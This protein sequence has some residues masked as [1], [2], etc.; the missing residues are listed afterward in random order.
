MIVASAGLTGNVEK[1]PVDT[2]SGLLTWLH[3]LHIGINLAERGDVSVPVEYFK[4]S[5]DMKPN[6]I[7]YRCL[8]VLSST[9]EVQYITHHNIL[10]LST[11]R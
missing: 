3:A 1:L 11:V 4:L 8:A 2:S 5:A 10:R 7:A 9:Y 6:P